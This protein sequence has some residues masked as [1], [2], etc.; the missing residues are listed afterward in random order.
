MVTIVVVKLGVALVEGTRA[1]LW[2]LKGKPTGNQP[3]C[4]ILF[5]NTPT[6]FAVM[7]RSL[8]ELPILPSLSRSPAGPK[9]GS[10]RFGPAWFLRGSHKGNQSQ[11]G[12]CTLKTDL[13]H[14]PIREVENERP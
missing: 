2:L 11:F 7:C 9:M 13:A 6:Y 14:M 3:F 10:S 4:G 5:K 8:G 1:I 12:W